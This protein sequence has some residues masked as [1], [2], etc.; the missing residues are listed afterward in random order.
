MPVKS[1]ARA[2]QRL[3][4]VL[5][6]SER[7]ALAR[8]LAARV[9]RAAGSCACFVA[10][11]CEDVATWAS[12]RGAGI[13]WTPGL[14]LSG[15]VTEAVRRLGVAGYDH[16]VVAHSDLALVES[17][18]CFGLPDTVTIAP[19]RTRLGS[20]VISLPTSSGFVFSYGTG[21]FERHRVEAARLGLPCVVVDDDR[22]ATDV[23][24]P[25]DLASL[26]EH[27]RPESITRSREQPDARACE[28]QGK[29]AAKDLPLV[30]AIEVVL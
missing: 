25:M 14:G 1:F 15:A 17:L 27:Y 4:D 16:A 19:D 9:L 21:S 10:C 7:A 5:D 13:L 3:S 24:L 28:R 18:E 11:D 6:G 20:N 30:P 26:P 12:E 22:L 2:K 29:L 23:D 8:E